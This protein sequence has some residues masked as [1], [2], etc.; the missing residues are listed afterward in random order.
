M[1]RMKKHLS[2]NVD[3][4]SSVKL[5]HAD[6][7]KLKTWLSWTSSVYSTLLDEGLFPYLKNA[8]IHT[9]HVS[10]L[11]CGDARIKKLNAEHRRK[12]YVTDV[13]SFPAAEGHRTKNIL[14]L[15]NQGEL[16]LGDLAIC[17]PQAKRQAKEFQIGFWDEFIHLFFHGLLHLSG[18]DHEVSVKEEKIMQRWEDRAL[19]L[20]SKAKKKGA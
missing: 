8:P 14:S 7:R 12:D 11:L 15:I 5:G 10:L 20:F 6:E 1:A 19:E 3:F 17:I 13:L 16:I 18:Y 4:N 2:L 9:V